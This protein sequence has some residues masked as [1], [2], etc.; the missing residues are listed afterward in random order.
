MVVAYNSVLLLLDCGHD[1]LHLRIRASTQ[2][3]LKHLV[4][5]RNSRIEHQLDN[6]PMNDELPLKRHGSLNRP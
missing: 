6:A 3:L 2:H 1:A 5:N 4:A